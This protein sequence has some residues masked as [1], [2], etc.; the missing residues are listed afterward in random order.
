MLLEKIAEVREW[1]EKAA[2]DLGVAE[3]IL[4][5]KQPYFGASLFHCQ[6]AAEKMLKAYLVWND[7]P[8]RKTHELQELLSACAGIDP[9]F[10]A[11]SSPAKTLTQYAVDYR[12]PGAIGMLKL[13]EVE[14]A[15]RL[16]HEIFT[17]VLDRLP[18]DVKP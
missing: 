13:Q 2:E 17:F 4:R 15:V 12:Y 5:A 9:Q 3:L 1:V 18:P 10:S 14:D 6:Q 16:A 11:L 7:R 8:F